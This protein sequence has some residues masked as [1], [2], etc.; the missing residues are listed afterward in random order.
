MSED[1]KE[2]E[3]MDPA[4]MLKMLGTSVEEVETTRRTGEA[5]AKR[6]KSDRRICICGHRVN[7][8]T[9]LAGVTFCKPARMEC[10]CKKC[11][12]VLEVEDT[13]MF[14]RATS[15]G[16]RLHALSQGLYN[17]VQR[18]KKAKWLIEFKCDRCGEESDKPLTPVPVTQSGTATTYPTGFDALL[19]DDC[20]QII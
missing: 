3:W 16:G 14:I 5:G 9:E 7:G 20:R 19:C 15:G 10:P 8:H 12:P 11:R 18:E 17:L 6:D 1:S 13:R 2:N 4:E